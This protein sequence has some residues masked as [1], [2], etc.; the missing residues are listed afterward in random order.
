MYEGVIT[1]VTSVILETVLVN[2]CE[3]AEEAVAWLLSPV[4]LALETVHVY[5]VPL[6]TMSPT[7]LSSIDIVEPEQI[8]EA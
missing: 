1:Y 7:T 4:T 5:C 8:S 6:G 2:C 3:G